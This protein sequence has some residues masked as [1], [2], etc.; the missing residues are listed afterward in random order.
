MSVPMTPMSVITCFGS[1]APDN[2]AAPELIIPSIIL[3]GSGDLP[4]GKISAISPI[5][6]P[7]FI[8]GPAE[9]S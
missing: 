5:V 9:L 1:P 8:P 3:P 2:N 7:I 6:V 4:P